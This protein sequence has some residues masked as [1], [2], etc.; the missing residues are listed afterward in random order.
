[1]SHIDSPSL[2]DAQAAAAAVGFLIRVDRDGF[3]VRRI[4]E[5]D[6]EHATDIVDAL[7]I[8]RRRSSK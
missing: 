5:L 1:M 6:E 2:S 4:G 3:A 7:S 8:V